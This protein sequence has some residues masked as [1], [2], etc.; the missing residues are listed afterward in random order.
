VSDW[1]AVAAFLDALVESARPGFEDREQL[2]VSLG[3]LHAAAAAAYPS[4]VVPATTFAAELARRLGAGATP[5]VVAA[6]RA[7][8]LCLAIA[9]AAGSAAAIASFERE[10]F[11]EIEH[12]GVRLRARPDQLDE[13]RSKLRQ[14]LF[15]SEP[16]RHAAVAS[17]A[18]KS[19][20]RT[21]LRV[22]ITRELVRLIDRG[23]REVALDDSMLHLV[24]PTDGPEL[25]A[26]RQRYRDDVDAAIR[27]ALI[28]LPAEVRALL[29][30]SVIDGWSIDRIGAL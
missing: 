4:L 26:L 20:L 24:A 12:A 7:G 5:T 27:A 14:V 3:R 23:R 17:F 22:V 16:R 18:G 28:G 13:V 10:L 6:T 21:Y 15:T 2:A 25:G 1:P 30:Y 11:D 8:H 29:R 9:C 19:D